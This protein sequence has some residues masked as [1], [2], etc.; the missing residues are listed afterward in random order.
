MGLQRAA[1]PCKT[2]W[3]LWSVM[4]TASQDRT[5]RIAMNSVGCI[6]QRTHGPA[7]CGALIDHID[8]SYSA[9]GVTQGETFTTL[10]HNTF[11]KAACNLHVR[12]CQPQENCHQYRVWRLLP[13]AV[14][15]RACLLTYRTLAAAAGTRAPRC[16]AFTAVTHVFSFRRKEKC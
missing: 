14:W 8:H 2:T 3:V 6:G 7:A 13:P 16:N 4:T 9:A 5:A 10:A 12:S 11:P 1:C 15:D